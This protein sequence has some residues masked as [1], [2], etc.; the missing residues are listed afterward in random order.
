MGRE[1]R[2][3]WASEPR[4]LVG[5]NLWPD[6]VAPDPKKDV[7]DTGSATGEASHEVPAP[8]RGGALKGEIVLGGAVTPPAPQ[9][10]ERGIGHWGN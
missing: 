4:R 10:G 8:D 2:D 9:A 6:V 7:S 1:K 5:V 3:P